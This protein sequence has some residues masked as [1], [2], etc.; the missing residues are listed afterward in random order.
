MVPFELKFVDKLLWAICYAVKIFTSFDG[1]KV[2]MP[3][4][5]PVI[6]ISFVHL[7]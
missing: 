4:F 1:P 6:T 7:E 2:G 3:F 5:A